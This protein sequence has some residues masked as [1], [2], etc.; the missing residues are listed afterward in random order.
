MNLRKYG[1]DLIIYCNCKE[2]DLNGISNV[3]VRQ[4]IGAWFEA[5]F[6][7]PTENFGNEIVWTNYYIRIENSILYYNFM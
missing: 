2:E 3:F 4:V 6:S 5:S 1:K 7:V